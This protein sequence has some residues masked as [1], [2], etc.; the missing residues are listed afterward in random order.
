MDIAH[1][2][3]Q[4]QL[5]MQC[6]ASM[7]E[8]VHSC[9]VNAYERACVPVIAFRRVSVRTVF[10]HCHVHACM[11]AC[12]CASVCVCVCV[13]ACCVCVLCVCGAR[14]RLCVLPCD[15]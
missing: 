2:L 9:C 1:I 6:P 8:R 14:A 3:A 5:R 4:S 10:A 12:V 13:C 11:H 7:G 15:V